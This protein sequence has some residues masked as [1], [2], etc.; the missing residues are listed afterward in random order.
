MNNPSLLSR[1]ISLAILLAVAVVASVLLK[2]AVQVVLWATGAI[3]VLGI[4]LYV[5]GRLRRAGR[6]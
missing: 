2:V 5:A 6:L 3:I 1:L 4:V